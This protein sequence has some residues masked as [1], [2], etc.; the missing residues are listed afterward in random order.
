[1]EIIYICSKYIFPLLKSNRFHIV[2]AAA[3]IVG[4]FTLKTMEDTGS[5]VKPIIRATVEGDAELEYLRACVGD[6]KRENEELRLWKHRRNLVD[7]SLTKYSLD[8]LKDIA[9]EE[10]LLGVAGLTKPRLM[11][12]LLEEGVLDIKKI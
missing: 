11:M 5:K 6:L 3:R 9:R 10:G 4:R 8:E 7:D 2:G 12:R 1:M